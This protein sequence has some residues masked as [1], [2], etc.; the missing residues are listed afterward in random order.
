MLLSLAAAGW[1][2]ATLPAFAAVQT[3][4]F[5]PPRGAAGGAL[6]GAIS[7]NAGRDAAIGA[8]VGGVAGAARR[9]SARRSG[10]CY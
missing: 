8:G 6:I 7:G 4:Q 10:A 9:G 1:I 5:N 3:A 2:I